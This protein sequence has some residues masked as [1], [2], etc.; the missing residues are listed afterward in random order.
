MDSPSSVQVKT[1]LATAR[2]GDRNVGRELLPHV[3]DELKSLARR[4]MAHEPAGQTL[5]P[6]ALVH[7]AYLRLVGDTDQNWDHTGHFY[8][9]AAEAMRRILIE[10]ARRVASKKRGGDAVRVDIPQ[11]LHAT[12]PVATLDLLALNDALE[13][14]EQLDQRKSDIVKLRYFVGLSIDETAKSLGISPAT[15][16]GDWSYARSWLHREIR[17]APESR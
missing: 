2:P 12:V 1:I 9:A 16:K 5:Q 6:T 11:S 4:K 3:Y 13:K 8:A 14:L 17:G 15:V 10:R 7:E